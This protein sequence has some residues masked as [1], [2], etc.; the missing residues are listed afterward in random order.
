MERMVTTLGLTGMEDIVQRGEEWRQAYL[1]TPHGQPVVLLN[2][3][4][5]PAHGH[6]GEH[7]PHREPVAISRASN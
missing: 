1:N 7:L 4:C 2:A 3:S 6:T 5:P